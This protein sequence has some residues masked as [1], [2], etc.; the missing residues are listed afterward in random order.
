MTTQMPSYVAPPVTQ[1]SQAAPQVTYAQAAPAVQYTTA[2]PSYVAAPVQYT[3]AAPQVTYTQAA[4]VSQ[5]A[6]YVAPPVM[7]VAAPVMQLPQVPTAPQ[8][9]TQGIPTPEQIKQQKAGYSAALDKQLKEA[10]ET[11]Q[12]ETKIEKEMIKFTAEKNIALHNMQVDEKLTES[13]ARADEQAT[14]ALCELNKA[15]VERSLQLSNQANGLIMDYQKK[16]IE[17][18]LAQKMYQFQ[19]AH[20]QAENKLAQDYNKEV[21]IANTG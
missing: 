13:M 16:A 4:P 21:A 5:V 12:K 2:A 10:I 14:L 11:V 7:Q 6:S 9:L 18:E 3:Q 1:Y 15:K 17:T 8:K 20:R 19:E